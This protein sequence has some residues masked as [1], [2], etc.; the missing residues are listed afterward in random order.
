MPTPPDITLAPGQTVTEYTEFPNVINARTTY[1][2][3]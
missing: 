1:T 2:V 3:F